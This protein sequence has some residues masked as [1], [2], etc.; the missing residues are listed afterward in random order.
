LKYKE[1][2]DDNEFYRS[3][4]TLQTESVKSHRLETKEHR[5]ITDEA[6]SLLSD[7]AG[8]MVTISR[9]VATCSTRQQT[10]ELKSIMRKV[11]DMNMKIYEMVLD[12]QKL[13]FQLPAQVDRQQPVYFEDAYGR[14]APFYIEFISSFDAFQAVMEVRFRH[15]PGLKKVQNVEYAIQESSSKRKLDLTAPWDSIFLPGRKVNMST[16]FRRPQT[17]MSSCPGCQTENKIEDSNKGSEIQW[18]VNISIFS[19]SY[20]LTVLTVSC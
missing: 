12:M 17:S 3:A 19:A 8:L 11:F 16:V 10:E 4:T 15:V 9:N 20:S 7:Q 5:K 13:Q 2:E 14:I 1:A 18:Y 6:K